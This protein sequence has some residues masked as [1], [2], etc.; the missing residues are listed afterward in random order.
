[1]KLSLQC[2]QA[3]YDAA[4]EDERKDYDQRLLASWAEAYE[5]NEL[6]EL[7]ADYDAMTKQG[8][9]QWEYGK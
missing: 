5:R 8:L 6:S 2:T 4:T 7:Q 9:D 1:M 3:T